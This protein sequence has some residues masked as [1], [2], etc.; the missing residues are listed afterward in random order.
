M[1]Y[2]DCIMDKADVGSFSVH[3]TRFLP[4][5]SNTISFCVRTKPSPKSA[6][7]SPEPQ[8]AHLERDGH[9]FP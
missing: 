4:S 2:Q 6:G 5:K 9:I 7:P 1:L 3:L 8:A